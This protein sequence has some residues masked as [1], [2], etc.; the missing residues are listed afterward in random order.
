MFKK[1]NQALF[2][3]IIWF[4]FVTILL[5]IPGKKLPSIPWIGLFQV[6]KLVHIV[7]FFILTLLFCKAAFVINKTQNWFWGIALFFS[8]YGLGMEFVQENFVTNRSFDV[9]DIVADAIGS[10][11]FLVYINLKPQFFK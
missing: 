11:S 4:T 3:A 1:N 9:W 6:D 5:C 10:F 7:L 2:I 8:I